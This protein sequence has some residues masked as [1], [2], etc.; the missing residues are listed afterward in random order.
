MPNT[1]PYPATTIK[2]EAAP[3]KAG[4]EWRV[5]ATYPTGEQEQIVG[6]ANEAEA[7]AWIGSPQCLAWISARGYA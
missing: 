5:V 1:P 7:V 6:F 2:F 3:L 4:N